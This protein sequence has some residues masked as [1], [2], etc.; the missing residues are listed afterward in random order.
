MNGASPKGIYMDND[1]PKQPERQ[2]RFRRWFFIVPIIFVLAIVAHGFSQFFS[3]RHKPPAMTSR[4]TPV[5]TSAAKIGNITIYLTGI[6]SVTPL[7][8]VTVK[9]RVDGQLMKV[10]FSEGKMVKKG[11]LLA[12]IDQRPFEVQLAQAEGQMMRDQ[13]L[14]ENA[15]LDL[16]RYQELWARNSV[17]RQQVDTQE[18]LVHQYE[19]AIKVDK[20]QIDGA[21]LQLKYCRIT[22]PFNGR[23]GLRLVDPGNMVHASD[24]TGLVVITKQQPITVTFSIPEDSLPQVLQKLNSGKRLTVEA[25]DREQRHLLANGVLLAV[26]NQVDPN[27]G[28]VRLKALFP[29]TDNAL[30]PNQFVNARL[31]LE[32]KHSVLVSAAA[33]QRGPKGTFVYVVRQDKTIEVRPVITGE[34]Q[35]NETAVS[36]GLRPGEPVVVDGTERLREGSY[37]KVRAEGKEAEQGLK[38]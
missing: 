29:N 32:T 16:K 30:F 20:A 31:R 8:T 26:D 17:Q 18:A 33:I 36:S 6:G 25:Y 19:A 37:V 3:A 10:L 7:S 11:E 22:A 35:D 28:T 2:M 15:R 27:T 14:L 21:R 38:K 34:T 23:A 4:P 24:A 5:E 9:T 13:S 1:Q 12:V